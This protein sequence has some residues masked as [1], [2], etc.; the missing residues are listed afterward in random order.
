MAFA[1]ARPY[2]PNCSHSRMNR[3]RVP[4][5]LVRTY[6][7]QSA[8]I[9]A[10]SKRGTKKTEDEEGNGECRGK[11]ERR[12]GGRERKNG[13]ERETSLTKRFTRLFAATNNLFM[14]S[15]L[16]PLRE[17]QKE[18]G[19]LREGKGGKGGERNLSSEFLILRN[20]RRI[21]EKFHS[22][23]ADLWHIISTVSR[24]S[25]GSRRLV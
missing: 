2:P 3:W 19:N 24:Y 12:E 14:E 6:K 16:K 22:G 8:A 10:D 5:R 20:R 15:D 7:S 23:P 13:E 25:K 17:R 4:E 9:A 1:L 18:K 21:P 11:R